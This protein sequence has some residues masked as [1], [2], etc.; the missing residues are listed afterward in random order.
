M[1]QRRLPVYLVLDT[2][3]SMSGEPIEAVRQGVKALVSDLRGDP[4]ALEGAYLSLISF[5]SEPAQLVPLTELLSFQEPTLGAG[6]STALGKALDLTLSCIA[7]EVVK[8]SPDQ[9]GDYKPLVFLMTDGQPTDEWEPAAERMKASKVNV[10]ACAAGPGASL[11][12]LKRI[13]ENV[14][15]LSSLQPNDMKAFF[16]WVSSS[17]KAV[18]QAIDSGAAPALP[19]IP[20]PA[21]VF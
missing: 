5:N 17:I 13:T 9:K 1:S 20:G 14:V 3:G 8:S 11:D 19:P 18:S 21:V 10:I 2:S 15:I 16:R 7:R 4:L 12:A 6:G